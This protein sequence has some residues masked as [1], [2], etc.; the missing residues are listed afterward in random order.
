MRG[1]AAS[2]PPPRPPSP[3]TAAGARLPGST[4][5][6]KWPAPGALQRSSS[7]SP[8]ERP[9]PPRP[10][11]AL[12]PAARKSFSTTDGSSFM[13]PDSAEA[14]R[15]QSLR[16]RRPPGAGTGAG[17]EERRR[18]CRARSAAGLWVQAW[19][20]SARSSRPLGVSVFTPSVRPPEPL[21]LTQDGQLPSARS[22]LGRL[23]APGLA[24]GNKAPGGAEAPPRPLPPRPHLLPR[25]DSRPAPGACRPAPDPVGAAGK[26]GGRRG[27]RSHISGLG[28]GSRGLTVGRAAGRQVAG[29]SSYLSP[30]KLVTLQ[31]W[32]C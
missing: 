8:T 7:V 15:Q 4:G 12:L 1:E 5:P 21:S 29:T 6:T 28:Q 30:Y 26:R 22:S 27:R 9:H 13:V 3:R 19:L 24:A 18:P 2:E 32:D 20:G 31:P 25:W 11:A 14:A 17:R 23:S 16:R 10:P